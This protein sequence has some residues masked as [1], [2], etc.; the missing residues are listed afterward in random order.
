MRAIELALLTMGARSCENLLAP[1][2]PPPG[3]TPSCLSSPAA[4][5][6]LST[7]CSSDTVA[8]N[9]AVT[10]SSLQ[11]AIDGAGTGATVYV[12]PGEHEVSLRVSKKNLTLAAASGDRSDTTLSGGGSDQIVSGTQSQL[13]LYNLTLSD[14]Y[15]LKGGAVALTRANLSLS[16]VDLTDNEASSDGG[17]IDI[18]LGALVLDTVSFTGNIAGD[19]GGAVR[20]HGVYPSSLDIL[21]STF[22]ENEADYGGALALG[23]VAQNEFYDIDSTDFI[24]NI[25]ESAGGAIF[26]ETDGVASLNISDSTFTG[27]DAT[28]GGGLAVS[29]SASALDIWFGE[30]ALEENT[31]DSGAAVYVDSGPSVVDLDFYLSAIAGNSSD[32]AVVEIS[33]DTI[34]WS[35]SSD[36]GMV[37]GKF[38]NASADIDCGCGEYDDLGSSESF[39]CDL[40][41]NWVVP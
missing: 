25:A 29:G 28:E 41:G 17:A 35:Y 5:P 6:D 23:E 36:W 19:A 13:T 33:D 31:A 22:E 34:V 18:E 40:D 20:M 32:S 37:G 30:S 4:H 12:C 9:G 27:N 21:D 39:L 11:D 7:Y 8:Y 14:G 3:Y 26:L 1:V 2:P 16:C 10:Y 38:D 24:D 15:A